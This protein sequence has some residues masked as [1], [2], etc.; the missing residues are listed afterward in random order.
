MKALYGEANPPEASDVI[1]GRL[2][3][4]ALR[5]LRLGINVVVDF[6]LWAR[7]ERTA[8]RQ[9][10][11]DVGATVAMRYLELDRAEQ[12]RRLD[13]RQTEEPHTTWHVL[14]ESQRLLLGFEAA[15]VRRLPATGSPTVR[16]R[17]GGV[18]IPA[19]FV[20]PCV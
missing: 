14:R 20:R 15:C 11:A 7:D 13:R 19:P 16:N 2:I 4:I 10:A 18:G 3:A 12:R 8:L 6:G 5:A 17:V 9:A 1:E